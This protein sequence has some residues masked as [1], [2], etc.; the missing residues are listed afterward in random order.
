[1]PQ[2]WLHDS[3]I[4]NICHEIWKTQKD[5]VN[6]RIISEYPVILSLLLVKLQQFVPQSGIWF[7]PINMGNCHWTLLCLE[8][9][10]SNYKALYFDPGGA[11]APLLLSQTLRQLRIQFVD[12][13]QKVQYDNFQCGIWVCWAVDRILDHRAR[14]LPLI[15][16]SLHQLVRVNSGNSRHWLENNQL[17]ALVRQEFSNRL[18]ASKQRGTLLLI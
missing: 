18:L 4:H 2:E 12:L 11:A 5:Q 16:F 17:I 9:N 14:N 15:S 7:F 10:N 8:C 13:L 6:T 1:M 3:Q